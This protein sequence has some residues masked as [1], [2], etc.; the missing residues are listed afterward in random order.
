MPLGNRPKLAYVPALD[1]IRAIAILFVFLFHAGNL[2]G[3]W[4]GVDMFFTL[5]GYLITLI[6]TTEYEATGFIFTGQFFFRRACRLLPAA[7][8]LIAVAVALS[9]YFNDKF[10]DT[11]IDAV[12][13][14]LY[15][16]DFRYA[17]SP[18]A[19]TMLGHLWSL[20]VEEQFYLI[21][22]FFLIVSLSL[23]GRKS[24]FY[25]VIATTV[26]IILWRFA[27]LSESSS[28]YYRIYFSFDTR[29][30]ELLIG[31]ALALWGHRPAQVILRTIK[32]SWPL[33]VIFFIAI[34]IEV[35]PVTKWE[36]VSSY[37]LIGA[38]TACLIVIVTTEEMAFLTQL[39]TLAPLVAFGRIS[40]GFYLWHYLIIHEVRTEGFTRWYVTVLAFAL[41]L[42]VSIGS[43]RLIEQP[44]LRFGRRAIAA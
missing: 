30:D 19:G 5:S 14:L 42:I 6:L 34:V 44:V 2:R 33:I 22:P 39:F 24:S 18:V 26:F 16:E 37:P 23:F 43:Y 31:S 38:A 11:T 25:V 15:V 3:G 4:V 41:T 20:S 32:L 27:I 9:F 17:F 12:A 40:Y 7:S 10:H 35:D 1:G 28:P 21:W 13:A 8:A 36:G 29:I